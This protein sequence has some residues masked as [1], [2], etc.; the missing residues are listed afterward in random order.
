M[1]RAGWMRGVMV[2]LYKCAVS[3]VG[4]VCLYTSTVSRRGEGGDAVSI[5]IRVFLFNNPII[6][7]ISIKRN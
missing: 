4:I 5:Y 2:F 7:N 6:W 1:Q 3:G